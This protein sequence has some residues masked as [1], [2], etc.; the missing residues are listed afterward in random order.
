MGKIKE[1]L[2]SQD[3]FG[4]TIN[5]NFNKEGDS[6]QTAIGGSMS[7]LIRIVMALYVFMNFKKMLLHEDDSNVVEVNTMDLVEYGKKAYN[8]TDM[9]IYHVLRK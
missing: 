3:M 4:H 8:E 5:L 7:I 9:F 2:R 1:K 6:H